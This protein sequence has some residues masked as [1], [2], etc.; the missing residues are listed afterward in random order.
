MITSKALEFQPLI[1]CGKYA[2]LYLSVELYLYQLNYN[3]AIC[4]CCVLYST[5]VGSRDFSNAVIGS[6]YEGSFLLYLIHGRSI[7]I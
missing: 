7:F 1:D 4:C 6:E 2:F 3:F 5:F